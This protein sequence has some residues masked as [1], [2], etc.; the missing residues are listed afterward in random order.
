MEAAGWLPP[1]LQLLTGMRLMEVETDYGQP[2]I[3]ITNRG[4]GETVA[5]LALEGNS[6]DSPPPA[7][8]IEQGAH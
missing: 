6:A 8:L 7:L 1:S 5:A 3:Q 4:P 2:D